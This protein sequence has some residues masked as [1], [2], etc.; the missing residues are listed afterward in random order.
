MA[1]G[2]VFRNSSGQT[3]QLTE[4]MAFPDD[5]TQ[6]EIIAMGRTRIIVPAGEVWDSWFDEASVS[7]DCMAGR[8][9][10]A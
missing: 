4:A 7:T 1:Q 8:D 9:Q 5:V 6:V 2:S 10:P 3:I